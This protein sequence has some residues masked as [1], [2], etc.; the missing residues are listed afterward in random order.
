MDDDVR[1][2]ILD[3]SVWIAYLHVD[4]SQHAKAVTVLNGR[5]ESVVVPEYVLVEVATALKRKGRAADAKGYV[6]AVLEGG[7]NF[8]SSD[9]L[10]YAA[11]ELFCRRDD[12]LSFTDTALLVLAQEYRVITFDSALAKALKKEFP[13]LYA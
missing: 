13:D 12:K 1:P 10:V 5:T 2:I 11:A 8:L 7:E 6:S 4:D 9:V 3:S